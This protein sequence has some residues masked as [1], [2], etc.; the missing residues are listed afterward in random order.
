MTAVTARAR[1]PSSP[2]RYFW[3]LRTGLG[4]IAPSGST[5]SRCDQCLAAPGGTYAAQP[6]PIVTMGLRIETS[7]DAPL[8]VAAHFLFGHG[9]VTAASEGNGRPSPAD[10]GAGDI[11]KDRDDAALADPPALVRAPGQHVVEVGH[12]VDADV[13]DRRRRIGRVV[14][15]GGPGAHSDRAGRAVAAGGGNGLR[16][17]L[18]GAYPQ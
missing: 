13:L 14:D 8:C 4:I 1:S 2:G 3:S 11:T 7:C 15:P 18:D 16:G 17:T 9:R 5:S 10:R 6:L 12:D